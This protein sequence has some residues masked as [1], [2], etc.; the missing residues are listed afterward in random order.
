MHRFSASDIKTT[1]LI[2]GCGLQDTSK[3]S[4]FLNWESCQLK[5]QPTFFVI[6]NQLKFQ[7][8]NFLTYRH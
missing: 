6:F 5:F 4:T 2:Q 1:A 8:V 3:R 7:P